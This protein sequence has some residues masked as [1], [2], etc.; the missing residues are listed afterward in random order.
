MNPHGR[1]QGRAETARPE[2]DPSRLSRLLAQAAQHHQAGRLDD[3]IADY[4][5]AAGLAPAH[6]GIHNNLG[7]ALRQQ[8]RLEEAIA[9]YRRVIALQ[10][11]DGGAHGNLG[12]ALQQAG[13]L[14]AAVAAFRRALR[15]RPDHA[16]AH[17]ALGAALRD[18]GA[19]KE[20][21]ACHRR[22][23]A[24]CPREAEAHHLLGAALQRQGRLEEAVASYRQAI[25]LQPQEAGVHNN[26]GTALQRLGQWVEA[27]ASFR[28]SLRL[29]PWDANVLSNLGTTLK[30][31]GRW[32]E[33][34]TCYRQAIALCPQHGPAHLNLGMGLLAEGA[35]EAGWAEY[36][37]RWRCAQAP[38]GFRQ[39]QW[40]G[41]P[42]Q[43]RT[44]LLHAEQGLGDTLQF[45]RY[46]ELA[47]ARG[48]RVVLE[49]Q[50]PLRRL[51][52]G[53]P[54]T[55]AVLAQGE[56]L[57]AFDLHC[58]LLSLPL[59][60]GTR[61]ESIPAAIPYLRA[62][63]PEAPL[64]RGRL[65]A[66]GGQGPRIGLVWAG[67]PTLA[68]DRERSLDPALLAPLLALPGLH[69]VSLQKGGP[70]APPGLPLTDLMPEVRDLAETA[71]LVA[72]LDL[73][74]SVD[75]AVA[76]L[77]GALGQ[78]VWLLD[79]FTPDWRWLRGRKDSPWYLSMRIYRQARPGDWAGV[80][81]TVKEDLWLYFGG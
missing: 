4:R 65:R 27:E 34:M 71:A 69:F 74:I 40:R 62:E 55:V 15:L 11:Q 51:L 60:L 41:E 36:E 47:A 80:L 26:L 81:E 50:P 9:C 77:A 79:R 5:H 48:L 52:Q 29:R 14:E 44:L 25:A 12:N 75:T 46:A 70:A 42:A 18:K 32:E 72:E 37:W 23:I 24:L 7:V 45:C 8:G 59:A 3:A 22:A 76:H 20:A 39:P 58:P 73:V 67:S 57:P 13:Q 1:P 19:L 30:E 6:P 66:M 28:H 10:P 78:T 16:P 21:A 49:V 35:F 31:L 43:G 53:L 17:N 64:W 63:A 68:R 2:A 56:A 33:A 61:L 54:G 38:R